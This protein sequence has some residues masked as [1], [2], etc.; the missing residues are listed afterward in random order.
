MVRRPHGVCTSCGVTWPSCSAAA[1]IHAG[2]GS[3]L[4]RMEAGIRAAV[5]AA[6]VRPLRVPPVVGAA[7]LGLDRLAAPPGAGARVRR[8]LTQDRILICS[9]G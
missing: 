1:L 7:L 8:A 4:R 6:D 3:F 2:D 5:P 9:E